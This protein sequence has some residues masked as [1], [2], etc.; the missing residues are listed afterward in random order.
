[1]TG[2]SQ[3]FMRA[4]LAA[5]AYAIAFVLT[6]SALEASRNSSDV[7]SVIASQ[8]FLGDGHIVGDLPVKQVPHVVKL[9][10]IGKFEDE[11]DAQKGAVGQSGFLLGFHL[12]I[13]KNA[14]VLFYVHNI[15]MIIDDADLGKR[16]VLINSDRQIKKKARVGKTDL[17]R[18]MSQEIP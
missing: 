15:R 2:S 7:R 13:Q 16:R 4:S 8:A 18:Y 14:A 9:D 6:V 3:P 17:D 12:L 1:M 10:G 5:A 11:L